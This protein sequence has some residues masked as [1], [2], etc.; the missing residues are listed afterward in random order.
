MTALEQD[1]EKGVSTIPFFLDWWVSYFSV[2]KSK[3]A[4]L[5]FKIAPKTH[6]P[7]ILT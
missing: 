6:Y 7:D 1:L 3:L 2:Y 4:K 5:F